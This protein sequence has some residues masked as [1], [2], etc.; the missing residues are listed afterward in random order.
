MRCWLAVAIE[1]H[2]PIRAVAHSAARPVSEERLTT[3]DCSSCP[4]TNAEVA[5]LARAP[6]DPLRLTFRAPYSDYLGRR[7]PYPF[8]PATQAG[9]N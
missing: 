1:I 8:E 9:A 3:K 5:E 6:T 7:D 2:A 4:R